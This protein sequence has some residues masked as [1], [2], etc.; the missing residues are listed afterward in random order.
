MSKCKTSKLKYTIYNSTCIY[1]NVNFSV[2]VIT[3]NKSSWQYTVST[4]KCIGSPKLISTSLYINICK[5]HV[6][7][8]LSLKVTNTPTCHLNI[9]PRPCQEWMQTLPSL[10]GMA[11]IQ[12]FMGGLC[13]YMHYNVPC[14]KKHALL[15]KEM[16]KFKGK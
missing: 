10:L 8:E 9:W 6:K 15:Y 2:E 13:R 1:K 16:P 4:N 5:V 7:L 11:V 3:E 12:L 14:S